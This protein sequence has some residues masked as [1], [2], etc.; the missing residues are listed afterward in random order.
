M[1]LSWSAKA[2]KYLLFVFNLVFFII[3]IVIL[4]VGVSVKAYYT[5]YETFLDDQYFSAPNLLI[6]IGVII[7]FIAFFGCCGAIKDN[8]C[9]MITFSTLLILVF[10][11]QLAAGIAGYALKNQTV[12]FLSKELLGSMGHYNTTNGTQITELWDHIQPQFQ[13]CGV[14][15]GTDWVTQLNTTNESVPTSC[16]WHIYGS[17]GY[18]NCTLE[19]DNIYTRGCLSAFGDYIKSHALTIGGV[20]IGFAVVQLL[21][22]VFACH[23]SSQFKMNYDN[24]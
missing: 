1:T 20:G 21:G 14:T 12:A 3:G 18:T 10:I 22:I 23:L 4:S 15:N 13:C 24:M 11:L 6:A 7:F 5:G 9:M 2:I 17:I 16:C 8:Y 19:S